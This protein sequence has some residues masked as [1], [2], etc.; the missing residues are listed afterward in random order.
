MKVLGLDTFVTTSPTSTAATLHYPSAASSTTQGIIVTMP[1]LP[2]RAI[3][4]FL[5]FGMLACGVANTLITKYQDNQCVRNCDDPDQSKH[6]NFEQP[7]WQTAQMFVGEAG[8]W[9]VVGMSALFARFSSNDGRG[10]YAAIQDD[11]ADSAMQRTPLL[12]SEGELG[13]PS[14]TV[15]AA[16]PATTHDHYESTSDS[17]D[18]RNRPMSGWRTLL[19]ALPAFCDICGTTLMNTGLL[20]V[21]AS[22]YQ[23]TRGVLV[24]FVGLFSVVFLHRRLSPTKWFALLVVVVGVGIVGLAG[25]VERAPPAVPHLPGETDPAD[26]KEAIAYAS[27]LVRR[28]LMAFEEVDED[29]GGAAVRTIFGMLLVFLAQMF[30]AAQFVLEESLMHSS[31]IGP[32]QMVG[33]EGAFGLLLTLILQALLHAVYGSTKSGAGGYFDMRQGWEDITSKRSIW[34]SSLV[35]MVCI[36]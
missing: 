5:V 35:I 36:G 15:N 26:P 16:N 2:S 3:I 8:C 30:T 6:Q 14:G 22:I 18:R 24:L 34:G 19:L 21:V 28:A 33:F 11:T 20:F 1:P 32:L 7:V 29:T 10:K 27:D 31:S 4:P 17:Q 9:L 12:S 13:D 23:M 25:V